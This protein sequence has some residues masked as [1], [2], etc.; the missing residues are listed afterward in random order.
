MN[1]LM[2]KFVVLQG[3]YTGTANWHWK[4]L[5]GNRFVDSGSARHWRTPRKIETQVP[6]YVSLVW[7]LLIE[8]APEM[9]IKKFFY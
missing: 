8:R 1:K 3:A 5:L 2:M 9:L 4:Y 7:S 6:F